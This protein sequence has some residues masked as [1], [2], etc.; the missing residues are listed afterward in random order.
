[1]IAV[2]YDKETGK[3]SQTVQMLEENIKKLGQAYLEVPEFHYNYD[4]THK[5]VDGKLVPITPAE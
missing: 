2:V 5:V 4:S 1:V 3:I